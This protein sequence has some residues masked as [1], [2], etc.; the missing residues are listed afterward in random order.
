MGRKQR[1]P[2]Q[3][4]GEVQLSC[5]VSCFGRFLV[6][7]GICQAIMNSLGCIEIEYRLFFTRKGYMYLV[8]QYSPSRGTG[9][10]GQRGIERGWIWEWWGVGVA[11]WVFALRRLF[12]ACAARNKWKVS[13]S[14][15]KEWLFYRIS[16]PGGIIHHSA[17]NK[18]ATTAVLQHWI[19]ILYTIVNERPTRLENG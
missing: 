1:F 13:L 12:A 17:G 3:S 4:V 16:F 14:A 15:C 2:A 18:F 9:K 11:Q 8:V 10:V 19:T 5:R 7:G 6:R